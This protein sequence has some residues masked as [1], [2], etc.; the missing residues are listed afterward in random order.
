[1]VD[2]ITLWLILPT[3]QNFAEHVSHSITSVR[4]LQDMSGCIEVL[5]RKLAL[6]K[7]VLEKY[8]TYHTLKTLEKEIKK[9]RQTKQVTQLMHLVVLI[10][11]TKFQ[12]PS[13]KFWINT[14]FS[15]SYIHESI[16]FGFP[17]S[18]DHA[19]AIN[20]YILYTK[21]YI[22]LAKLKEENKKE[23]LT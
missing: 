17:G 2:T 13:F 21:H 15:E 18:S 7:A 11:L 6:P 14:Y 19:I 5:L 12:I 3:F 8:N 23:N 20:Y 16:L 10:P 22:Y 1:M 9:A 4:Y